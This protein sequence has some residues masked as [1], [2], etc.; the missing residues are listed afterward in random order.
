[1]GFRF[2]SYM[3]WCGHYCSYCY[4]RGINVRFKRWEIEKI[5]IADLGQV[6]KYFANVFDDK[7]TNYNLLET[8]IAHRYPI[9]MG[10]NTDCFQPA[11]EQ[12]RISFRFINEIMNRYDYPYCICTK[13]DLVTD[14]LYMGIYR[15]NVNFQFTL[16]TLN[17]DFLEKIE[18]GAPSAEKRLQAIKTLSERGYFVGCRISPYIPEYMDDLEELVNRLAEVGCRHVIS[19]LLRISPILNKV[20]IGECGFDVVRHYKKLGA[21]MNLG[22]VR[23]PLLKKIEYQKKL[24]ELCDKHGMTFATCA[25]EDPSF[26]T[27]T[28]CCGFDG[29]EKFKGCPS[30]TYDTAFNLCKKNGS[31][32][33]DDLLAAGWCPDTKGLREVWDKGYFENILM[34][35]QFE[36]KTKRYKFVDINPILKKA[37]Q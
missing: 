28:N 12:Y 10:T 19:E 17:Q 3:G 9:R 11:E 25:D 22:Y 18:R 27:V 31:V 1:M 32:S 26:H 33:F 2:D 34:N 35:L 29:I 14:P 7:K 6:K 23:Y 16:S 21:R 37:N 24:K 15:D 5:K 30:A 8:C 4:A 36:P 20:M 13:S